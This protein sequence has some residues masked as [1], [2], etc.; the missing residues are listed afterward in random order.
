MS[1]L[2]KYMKD[3]NEI[4]QFFIDHQ[5]MLVEYKVISSEEKR[6]QTYLSDFE[7]DFI[8]HDKAVKDFFVLEFPHMSNNNLYTIDSN[9]SFVFDFY[10]Y[11]YGVTVY[12]SDGGRSFDCGV[13]AYEGNCAL[14]YH[15]EAA[16][17]YLEQFGIEY[18][19]KDICKKTSIDSFIQDTINFVRAL[20][21]INN[22]END[23][24]Y[25]LDLGE[26]KRTNDILSRLWHQNLSIKDGEKGRSLAL[27][28]YCKDCLNH[29]VREFNLQ[30]Y[31]YKHTVTGVFFNEEGKVLIR[32]NLK[33]SK[34]KPYEFS[35]KDYVLYLEEFGLETLQRL[36]KDEFGFHF[37]FDAVAPAITI[38]KEG[39]INDYFIVNKYNVLLE[40]LKYDNTVYEY[41]WVTK[42][43]LM[44]L[45][46]AGD[47]GDYTE[48]FIELIYE[49]RE[50]LIY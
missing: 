43:E 30:E 44:A 34:N 47:F 19:T 38:T 35:V 7:R 25:I 13:E 6:K 22:M 46:K 40:E 48:T 31:G 27:F 36:I 10:F 21:T 37:Y 17:K 3:F 5:N 33:E 42:E 49:T 32:R 45:V 15:R 2:S 16:K 24:P 1:E 39:I 9:D 23:P 50:H 11:T 41:D 8:V 12:I 26:G 14:A 20:Q 28:S 18:N 29:T 4:K